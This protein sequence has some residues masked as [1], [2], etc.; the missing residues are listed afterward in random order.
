MP[1]AAPGS[2]GRAPALLLLPLWVARAPAGA[3]TAASEPTPMQPSEA[4]GAPARGG[5]DRAGL[6]RRIEGL[7]GFSPKSGKRKRHKH[8]L[9]EVRADFLDRRQAP[10][11]APPAPPLARSARQGVGGPAPIQEIRA[12]LRKFMFMVFFLR[13]VGV[14]RAERARGAPR[15]PQPAGRS[16]RPAAHPREGRGTAAARPAPHSCAQLQSAA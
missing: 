12:D 8:K 15:L 7:A 13:L 3:A 6:P 9:S 5:A 1:R 16:S 2:R 4:G 14:L 11:A 10:L